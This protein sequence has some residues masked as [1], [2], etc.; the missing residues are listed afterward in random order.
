MVC[1]SLRHA[2]EELLGQRKG[3]DAYATQGSTMGIP[4][5]YPWANRLAERRFECRGRTVDL[6]AAPHRFRPDGMHGA[7][8][9]GGAWHVL[10][11]GDRHILAGFDWGL[12]EELMAAFPFAHRV[13]LRVELEPDRL[14]YVLRVDGDAPVSFGL[15][16]YFNVA[17]GTQLQVPVAERL[18]LDERQLPT[19]E[20]VPAG[21]LEQPPVDAEF[22]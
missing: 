9:A 16:P 12:D 7:L 6:D 19:G 10:D 5:L 15:H 21:D 1:T 2:G 13:T 14:H 4:L 17:D 20:R 8:A 18:V 22:T 3:L 11:D